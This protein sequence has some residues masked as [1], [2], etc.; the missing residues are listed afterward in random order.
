MFDSFVQ[1]RAEEYSALPKRPTIEE[2]AKMHVFDP[3]DQVGELKR[4]WS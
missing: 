1:K 4:M 2:F 3:F